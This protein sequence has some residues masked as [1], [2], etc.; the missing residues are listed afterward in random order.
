AE[1]ETVRPPA[2]C[3]A[4][5]VT[6]SE[7]S[8]DGTRAADQRAMSVGEP[9][10]GRGRVT[11]EVRILLADEKAGCSIEVRPEPLQRGIACGGQAR[12]ACDCGAGGPDES[13]LGLL[14]ELRP[15]L[16]EAAQDAADEFSVRFVRPGLAACWCRAGC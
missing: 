8:A 9:V 10:A 1:A 2:R 5:D 11:P 16:G 4:D 7:G 14:Q 3:H 12:Q 15:P 13:L 6:L